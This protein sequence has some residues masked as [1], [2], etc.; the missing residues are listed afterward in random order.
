MTTD[1]MQSERTQKQSRRKLLRTVGV[2]ATAGLAATIPGTTAAS[3]PTPPSSGNQTESGSDADGPIVEPQLSE[4]QQVT[5]SDYT[6][7]SYVNVFAG[8]D[9]TSTYLG[10]ADGG[11]NDPHGTTTSGEVSPDSC[12]CQMIEV[13]WGLGPDGWCYVNEIAPVVVPP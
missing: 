4:G 9:P 12:D 7:Y 13:D 3:N 11:P 8:P 5:D 2:A 10:Q 1:D 6:D